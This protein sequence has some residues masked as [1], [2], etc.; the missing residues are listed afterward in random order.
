MRVNARNIRQIAVW[1]LVLLVLPI[2]YFPEMFGTDL[3]GISF[4]SILVEL[5]FYGM[6]LFLFERSA[7]LKDISLG[8]VICLGY[9]L[10]LGSLLGLIFFVI[11]FMDFS[12]SMSLSLGSYLP[13]IILQALATPFILRSALRDSV[14]SSKGRRFH[15]KS[16]KVYSA[17]DNTKEMTT[18]PQVVSVSQ[19][20]QPSDSTI[21]EP[22]KTTRE[23]KVKHS[24]SSN[25][26]G[27]ENA[28]KY[29][30]EN[31][32]VKMAAI[33]DSEGL[34][35][36]N[37]VRGG[38]DPED[39]SPLALLFEDNNNRL[40]NRT[41][42]GQVERIGLTMDDVRVIVAREGVFCLMVVAERQHDEVL[43]V[44]IEQALEM[45]R[46]YTAERYSNVLFVNAEKEYVRSTE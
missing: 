25:T 6:V 12:V 28:T 35:L 29:I 11:Y 19:N 3:G 2:I 8:T 15:E 1:S 22:D 43:N 37:F 32:S 23:F 46:K 7:T 18:Q 14:F 33:V 10:V 34:L 40:L 39:W 17:S 21:I 24:N 44:R 5:F 4:T 36:G 38:I 31:G 42:F 16:P 26:N 45:I 9:R 13:V 30:G 41:G 27:F 20:R